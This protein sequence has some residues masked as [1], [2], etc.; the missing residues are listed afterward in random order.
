MILI[1]Q[2]GT[3]TQ[4]PD[5]KKSNPITTNKSHGFPGFKWVNFALFFGKRCVRV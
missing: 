3:S 1:V 2:A 5:S 4:L